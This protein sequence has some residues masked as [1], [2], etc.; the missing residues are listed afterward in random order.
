MSLRLPILIAVAVLLNLL[1]FYMI[2]QMVTSDQTGLAV[3]EELH[4][5]DFV[6]LQRE[7]P[8]PERPP[9]EPP[10]EIPPEER[11]EPPP[12]IPQPE[13]PQPEQMQFDM[14]TPN[15]D[16]PLGIDG[17]PYMGDF[18]RT[19]PPAPRAAPTR[20]EI[21]LDVEPTVR[22]QPQYPPR[23]L[24]AGIEGSVTVEFTIDTD[25][26]VKDPE[27]VDAD[28]PRIFDDAVLRAIRRWK[29]EP[30]IVDGVA[31]EKRARQVIRFRLQR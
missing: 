17:A 5:V 24:R 14:P 31:I 26:S 8:E 22:I 12:D 27:I 9:E 19:P 25:G 2:H 28:P 15:I 3:Y 6:R 4:F 7:E 13:V 1:L 23:A 10:E 11:E 18:M 29:F 16:I 30:E 20:P 21:A